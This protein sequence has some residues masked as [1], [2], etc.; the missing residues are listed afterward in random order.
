[1]SASPGGGGIKVRIEAV[2]GS[3]N[4]LCPSCDAAVPSEAIN[5]AEG[6]CK[7]P[8]CG[9]V[10]RL[11]EL[12]ELGEGDTEPVDLD[13]PPGGCWFRERNIGGGITVGAENKRYG[14]GGFLLG[15]SV[16]WNA[17]TWTVAG[18]F[19]YGIVSGSGS[20]TGPGSGPSVLGILFLLGICV[21]FVPFFAIGIGLL[22][23]AIYVMFG[24]TEVVVSGI[25]GRVI[26]R[27]GPL[28]RS[29]R[30]DTTQVESVGQKIE[31]TRDS[32]GDTHVD[33]FINIDMRDGK[34]IKLG[35][36]L[37]DERRRYMSKA[38]R[39]VLVPKN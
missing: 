6:F 31:T 12:I 1:M 25:D 13:R 7:C 39:A 16:F 29:K 2:D 10:H 9:A 5:I 23:T 4:Y 36:S 11:S 21:F 30:F 34:P 8:A 22:A 20:G 32:S 3:S 28:S 15:F 14:M 37:T 33:K 38:L 19:L 35:N 26:R 17:M 24:Q 18:G 27:L